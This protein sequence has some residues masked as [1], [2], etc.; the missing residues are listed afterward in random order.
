MIFAYT[1]RLAL[2]HAEKFNGRQSWSLM[3]GLIFNPPGGKYQSD[4]SNPLAD[5][6]V[7]EMTRN[8]SNLSTTIRGRS[9][10]DLLGLWKD[11]NK[12]GPGNNNNALDDN[13]D[14]S[15]D[16]SPRVT[17]CS[18]TAF[19]DST[20]C[21]SS[22]LV[23]QGSA[24]TTQ[25]RLAWTSP[26]RLQ[27]GSSDVQRSL[28]RSGPMNDN[29]YCVQQ[30]GKWDPLHSDRSASNE[31]TQL[32]P[33]EPLVSNTSTSHGNAKQ[34]QLASS[35]IISTSTCSDNWGGVVGGS[36]SSF[37][38]KPHEGPMDS[39]TLNGEE[40]LTS[41]RVV[42][43]E[44]GNCVTGNTMPSVSA[45]VRSD[46]SRESSAELENMLVSKVSLNILLAED[47]AIN[48][49]VASRQ[50]EK[51]GHVVTI[52]GD[53]QQALDVMCCRHDDFD[54]VLMDVQVLKNRTF[55]LSVNS[56]WYL[57]CVQQVSHPCLGFR[58]LGIFRV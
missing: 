49:K 20:R 18:V 51:H 55:L 45:S 19:Q 22:G 50:L 5:S 4:S 9:T 27:G 30:P 21:R 31:V 10:N 3:G 13:S 53:G 58:F 28:E 14:C 38:L 26:E 42:E 57:Y 35:Q 29:S 15:N 34:P 8:Y 32:A 39:D 17:G 2:H 12:G 36:A 43:R 37:V 44:R 7:A 33:K 1:D 47:N 11:N 6:G 41:S 24:G 25:G 52:V 40:L 23:R 48:Q 54:L 46:L 16:S 56:K